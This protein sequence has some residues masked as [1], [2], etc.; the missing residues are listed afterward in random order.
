MVLDPRTQEPLEEIPK[1]ERPAHLR[2]VLASH[3]LRLSDL[4]IA[5]DLRK[6]PGAFIIYL[7]AYLFGTRLQFHDWLFDGRIPIRSTHNIHFTKATAENFL[8]HCYRAWLGW[9]KK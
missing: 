8:S 6:G 9:T 4:V 3:E 2:P 5:E 1:T 7:L